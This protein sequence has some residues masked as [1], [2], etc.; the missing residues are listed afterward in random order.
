MKV[1]ALAPIFITNDLIQ[2]NKFLDRSRILNIG[3][4]AAHQY[5]KNLSMYSISKN[6]LYT[7]Y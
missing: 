7:S 5:F 6:A 2:R 3:T 4:Q 1:N